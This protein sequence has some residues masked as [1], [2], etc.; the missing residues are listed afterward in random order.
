MIHNGIHPPLRDVQTI[1]DKLIP[2]EVSHVDLLG[3]EP[4]SY[5]YIHL[6]LERLIAK[7]LPFTVSTNGL[8]VD[9]Q[10]LDIL[11]ESLRSGINISLEGPDKATHEIIR[12][13]DTFYPTVKNI[14]LITRAMEKSG[15]TVGLS[16]TLN[17]FNIK[18]MR[19]MQAFAKELGVDILQFAI[20][21]KQGNARQHFEHL[22][23]S[24]QDLIMTALDYFREADVDK[25]NDHPKVVFGFLDNPMSAILR[26]LLGLNLPDK[27]SG[28]A[29]ATST[30]AIDASGR[31][32]P[33]MPLSYTNDQ[34][35]L[36][37]FGFKDNSLLEHDF[38]EIWQSTGFRKL[39][40][41]NSQR[42]H[43]LQAKPCRNCQY[44]GIC[45]PCPL[46]YL[47]GQ[48]LDQYTCINRFEALT[49]LSKKD[50]N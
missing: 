18:R 14:R 19:D 1:I 40:E 30:A 20:V 16:C 9:Q 22:E 43:T 10:L 26:N 48:S 13:R 39:R 37:Y 28:C 2:G 17:A 45:S 42:L 24:D 5:P 44:Q 31:L 4:L 23:V 21:N 34:K 29:G 25:F 8:L 11:R 47:Q 32:W 49:T 15:T 36:Q 46:P 50:R 3:G 35:I 6:V 38:Y 27:V 12:G 33:C 7:G 41:L